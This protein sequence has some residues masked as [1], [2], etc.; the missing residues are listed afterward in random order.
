MG[1]N[2]QHAQ[3]LETILGIFFQKYGDFFPAQDIRS[4]TPKEPPTAKLLF[5]QAQRATMHKAAGSDGWKPYELRLL[6]LPAWTERRKV[7]QLGRD[8]H[9]SPKA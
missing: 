4:G 6:P 2:L 5:D 3:A 8:L 1:P 9:K 7:M